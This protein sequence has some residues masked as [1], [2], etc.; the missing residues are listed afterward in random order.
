MSFTSFIFVGFLIL[1][2]LFW[3]LTKK[4]YTVRL[5]YLVLAS[6]VFYG[7]VDWR[8][9]FFLIAVNLVSYWGSK[10]LGKDTPHRKA[11]LIFSVLFNAG[12]LVFFRYKGILFANTAGKFDIA[13]LGVSFYTVQAVSYLFDVYQG[14]VAPAKTLLVFFAYQSMFPK[15]TAGPIE[16]SGKLL[17]QLEQIHT[18]T[19]Q[20]RWEGLKL[21]AIG[22]FKKAVIADN[23]A[24][25]VNAGFDNPASEYTHP[26]FWWLIIT[27]FAFQLYYDF[28]GYSNIA[29]GLARWM[30][31]ELS[32][33]FDHPYIATSMSEFWTRWHIS[34]SNWLRD[35][36]F[37]PLSRT[38]WGRR[39][40]HHNMWI[41]LLF[42]GWW[43][44]AGWMY[45][46]WGSL[47]ALF[48]SIEHWTGWHLRLKDKSWGRWLAVILVN[49]QV[50][51]AW[52]FFRANTLTQ[53]GLILKTMFFLG[54]KRYAFI[55]PTLVYLLILA[56]FPEF[57]HALNLKVEEA[58]P[59]KWRPAAEIGMVAFFLIV[60]IF[61]RAPET[62]F[63]YF[64]F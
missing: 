25:Y 60:T 55:N 5:V 27:A 13:S 22:Y 19:E 43:H 50:W 59:T 62:E 44:G 39:T 36:I 4:N 33:N 9:I 29:R 11:F 20:D 57:L 28:S 34:F 48:I 21:V 7:W 31:Y 16:R 18:T 17:P 6:F 14:R 49:F 64:Q 2:F 37:I 51:I 47:H 3:P 1:F 54:L 32:M 30:G 24:V 46:I 15:L 38:H 8:L 41:T 26:L 42:S 58:I 52:V 23:L 63:V 10:L 56:A 35:Y 61:L 45:I 12:L 53:A 40:K